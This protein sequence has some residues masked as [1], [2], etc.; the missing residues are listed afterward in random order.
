MLQGFGFREA[1][2]D[3]EDGNKIPN[4]SAQHYFREL[5]SEDSRDEG[6]HFHIVGTKKYAA[7]Y[8]DMS[9]DTPVFRLLLWGTR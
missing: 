6:R 5:P 2:D 3:I 1:R 9:Q 4:V 8:L 7:S